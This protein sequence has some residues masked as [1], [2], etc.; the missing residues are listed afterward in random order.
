M[1]YV[2]LK[3]QKQNGTNVISQTFMMLQI[4]DSNLIII[5]NNLLTLEGLYNPSYYLK[6]VG[7]HQRQKGEGYAKS[8]A[9]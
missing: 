7:R 1:S 3:I 2:I 8:H 9:K 4:N 5:D 6:I